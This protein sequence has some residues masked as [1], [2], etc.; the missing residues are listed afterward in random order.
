MP[1]SA[2][3]ASLWRQAEGPEGLPQPV[4]APLDATSAAHMKPFR[5]SNLL[6]LRVTGSIAIEQ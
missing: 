3:S 5:P 6:T 1:P 2:W 4:I